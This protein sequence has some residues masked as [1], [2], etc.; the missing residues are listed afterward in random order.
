LLVGSTLASPASKTTVIEF[1]EN[2]VGVK[3]THIPPE[4]G[5]APFPQHA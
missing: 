3:L 1:G 4:L 5:G 2:T